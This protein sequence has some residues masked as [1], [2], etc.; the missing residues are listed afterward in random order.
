VIYELSVESCININTLSQVN[1][2]CFVN[3]NYSFVHFCVSK[4]EYLLFHS[5]S[6]SVGV[7]VGGGGGVRGRLFH[8]VISA[9]ISF[10]HYSSDHICLVK[11]MMLSSVFSHFMEEANAI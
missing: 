9:L 6:N 4:F 5:H 10:V 8:F 7:C 3:C 11:S 2:L 1:I